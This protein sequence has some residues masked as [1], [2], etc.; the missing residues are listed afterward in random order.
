MTKASEVAA[1][2][3]A[4]SE[5]DIV[6]I[7]LGIP[8]PHKSILLWL[9]DVCVEVVSYSE[10]NRMSSKAMAIVVAPNLY[11][12][13][14]FD[15]TD[16]NSSLA[17]I[18]LSKDYT[19]FCTMLIAWRVRMHAESL[20][21]HNNSSTA[22]HSEPKISEYKASEPKIS[23]NNI[24]EPRIASEPKISENNI[25][26]PRIAKH[27]ILAKAVPEEPNANNIYANALLLDDGQGQEAFEPP[28]LLDEPPPM[29]PGI[30]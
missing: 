9:L 11:K 28:V 18:Q 8:E 1:A 22:T 29:P 27:Q 13:P 12:T 14:A 15:P 21:V 10:Y 6:E 19:V 25:S 5:E 7:F 20:P 16:M 23:E 4:N 3:R 24:S 26:E 2:V 17:A 30:A